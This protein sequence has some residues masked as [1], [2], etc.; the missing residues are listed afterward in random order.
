MNKVERARLGAFLHET[1]L[2]LG[3]IER[4]VRMYIDL[5][6][7]VI[8]RKDREIERLKKQLAAAR[9]RKA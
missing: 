1:R 2:H 4:N 9:R 6:H 3:R 8:D 5:N 7:L